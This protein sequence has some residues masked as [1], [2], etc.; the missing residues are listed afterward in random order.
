MLAATLLA[1]P[2]CGGNDTYEDRTDQIDLDN[3]RDMD[4][5]TGTA[6]EMLDRAGTAVADGAI[7]MKIQAQYAADDVVKGHE[8]DVDTQNGTVTLKGNVESDAQREAAERI[9]RETDGV[10][11]VDNQLR[12]QPG[13]ASQ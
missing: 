11:S 9:A 6:G 4:N 7:T 10:N 2:A 12:V 13:S 1:A 3:N 8:I 5:A